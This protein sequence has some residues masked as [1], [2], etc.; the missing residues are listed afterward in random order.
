[1]LHFLIVMPNV[2]FS[3]CYACIG[4]LNGFI[5]RVVAPTDDLLVLTGLVKLFGIYIVL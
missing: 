2:A 3:Y 4:M 5:L 1:M